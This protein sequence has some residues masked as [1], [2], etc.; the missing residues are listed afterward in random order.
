MLICVN[1]IKIVD[2]GSVLVRGNVNLACLKALIF[3]LSF[4]LVLVWFQKEKM[5]SNFIYFERKLSVKD[6][7]H[8]KEKKKKKRSLS[9]IFFFFFIWHVT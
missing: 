9:Q 6:G 5:E 3:F 4:F 1:P 7:Y 2:V 8:K